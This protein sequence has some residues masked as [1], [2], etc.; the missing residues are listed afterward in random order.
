MTVVAWDGEILA[1]D[2]QSTDAGLRRTVTKIRRAPDGRLI[3]AAGNTN[4]CEALRR[5]WEQ[6]ADPEQFP[7]KD[8]TSHLLVIAPGGRIEF[9][10]GHPV[11]AVYE[12]ARFA[13]GSGRDYA[14]AAMYLGKNAIEAVQIAAHFD[15]SCGGGIDVLMF[16][17]PA[18][19]G[20]ITAGALEGFHE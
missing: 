4:I 18:A 10:D 15:V 20:A 3:G 14:E 5:W 16:D 13:M 9:Y 7:D 6:G 19:S 8:K 12:A 1:A 11:P 17:M 2:R